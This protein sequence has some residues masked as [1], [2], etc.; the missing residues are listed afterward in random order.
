MK[1]FHAWLVY[2]VCVVSC[3]SLPASAEDYPPANETLVTNIELSGSI[4]TP[5]AELSAL[6]WCGDYLWLIPQYL[7]FNRPND[8]TS[9]QFYRLT[10]SEV[11]EYLTTLNKGT[12]AKPLAPLPVTVKENQKLEAL[13]GYQGI[14][15][16]ACEGNKAFL[17]IEINRWGRREATVL[18][19]ALYEAG[20][21]RI[22]EVSQRHLSQTKIANKG[23][24]A[25]VI[26]EQG[27]L[28]LHEVNSADLQITGK[29]QALLVE[30]S[31]RSIGKVPMVDVPYR[32]TDATA[33]SDDGKFWVINYLWAGDVSIQRD[34]DAFWQE[35]GQGASHAKSKH[36]ERLIE[37]QWTGTEVTTTGRA[38]I[39]LL[40]TERNGRNWEGIVRFEDV[41]FLMVTDKHPG[42]ML[43][44]VPYEGWAEDLAPGSA[45]G[46]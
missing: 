45:T 31:L 17:A 4:A 9:G 40:L 25:L 24:E 21:W 36:V 39:N 6:G 46:H 41:G 42:T 10:R 23:N 19:T 33:A 32:I 18:A 27:L 13:S 5:N 30:K 44:Y 35:Y 34:H 38:P 26:T 16:F 37:L 29:P 3:F 8:P 43:G 7:N 14:E 12:P 20:V 28:S 11:T 2:L 15:A 22:D 1:N